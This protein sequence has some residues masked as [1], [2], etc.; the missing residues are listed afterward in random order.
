[1]NESKAEVLG[2]YN[3]LVQFALNEVTKLQMKQSPLY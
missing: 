1:M 3:C 2:A